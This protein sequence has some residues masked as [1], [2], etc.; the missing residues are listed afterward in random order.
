[1]ALPVPSTSPAD[2]PPDFAAA[3]GALRA[4]IADGS[5]NGVLL[6]EVEAPARVAPFGLTLAAELPADD[7]G[8]EPCASGRFVVLHDPAGQPGWDGET[9]LVAFVRG[10]VDAEM[11]RDPLLAEVAWSWLGDALAAREAGAH[12][13][14]GTVTVTAARR[15]GVLATA[16][17]PVES[18]LTESCEVELRCSWT[19][20]VADSESD[21]LLRHA[22]AFCDLLATTAGRP[23]L[24]PGVVALRPRI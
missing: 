8:E 1:V 10:D 20:T 6:T 11:A 4:F 24:A 22:T 16:G 21:W 2:L 9:R 13:C 18:Q 15:F 19:P 5:V 14:G 12:A 7:P 17:A 23:P 3:C